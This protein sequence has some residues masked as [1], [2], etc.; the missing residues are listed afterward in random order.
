MISRDLEDLEG[1][2]DEVWNDETGLVEDVKEK[3]LEYL[4]HFVC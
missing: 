3:V 1:W 4:E 2:F